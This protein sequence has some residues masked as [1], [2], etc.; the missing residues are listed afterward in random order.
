MIDSALPRRLGLSRTG[1]I[2]LYST[3]ADKEAETNISRAPSFA[4]SAGGLVTATPAR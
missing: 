4:A 3:L 1:A 2:R